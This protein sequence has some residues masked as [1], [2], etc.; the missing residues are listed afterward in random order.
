MNKWLDQLKENG[1]NNEVFTFYKKMIEESGLDDYDQINETFGNAKTIALI[2]TEG[3]IE[4]SEDII[5]K[6]L[7]VKYFDINA[8]GCVIELFTTKDNTFDFSNL[9]NKFVEKQNENELVFNYPNVEIKNVKDVF[10][11]IKSIEKIKMMWKTPRVKVGVPENIN[12]NLTMK[13][14][15]LIFE[16]TNVNNVKLSL[17][18]SIFKTNKSNFSTIII[19]EC[20]N[21]VM[22]VTNTKV[23]NILSPKVINN[24]MVKK[25]NIKEVAKIYGSHI[26][27]SKSEVNVL[28][29]LDLFNSYVSANNCE[30]NNVNVSGESYFDFSKSN[31]TNINQNLSNSYIKMSKSYTIKK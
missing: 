15:I 24:V 13:N 29:L 14:G 8:S 12:L 1:V 4:F 18:A 27:I 31:V 9:D 6:E 11:A 2:E 22:E 17:D 19:N 7:A 5:E 25:S 3:E 10:S 23:N 16:N 20:K 26:K 30:I 21:T 28:S